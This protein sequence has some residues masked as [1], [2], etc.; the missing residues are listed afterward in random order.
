MG[1]LAEGRSGGLAS[2]GGLLAGLVDRDPT[3]GLEDASGGSGLAEGEQGKKDGAE[4]WGPP[5]SGCGQS[6]G[7]WG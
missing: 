5:R 1:G 4:L 7:I 3:A 2:V 6:D